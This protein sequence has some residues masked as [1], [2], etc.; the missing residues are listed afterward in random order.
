[1]PEYKLQLASGAAARRRK[2]KLVLRHAPR[3]VSMSGCPDMVCT[4][5]PA[6]WEENRRVRTNCSS[7]KAR[8][9]SLLSFLLLLLG[10]LPAW[11]K[12]AAP[13]PAAACARQ[14]KAIGRALIAYR[15][16]HHQ[17]P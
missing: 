14:L 7:V 9:P 15:R 2:L 10:A 4:S 17:L 5:S 3:A 8:T 13:D 16:D 12:V 1:M 6:P 11:G